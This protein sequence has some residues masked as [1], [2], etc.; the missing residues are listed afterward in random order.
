MK[1]KLIAVLVLA[2][3]LPVLVFASVAN[4]QTFRSGQT[5]SIASSESIDGAAFITGSAVDVAGTING[6]L[7]CAGQNVT[8]SGNVDGDVLC[9]AQTITISGSVTGDVRLAAQTIAISGDVKGSASIAAQ[10]ITIEGQGKI[11]RDAVI[12]GQSTTINGSIARDVTLS[13]GSAVINTAIGRNISAQIE[14]LTLGK[15]AVIGGTIDYTS[16]EMLTKDSNAQVAGKVTY[17]KQE[18]TQ[19]DTSNAYDVSGAIFSTLMLIVSALLLVLIFPRQFQ[20]TT[21]ASAVSVKH[22]MFALLTGFVAS[23]V[24]PVAIVILLITVVGIPLGILMLLAW[25]I[26]LILSISFASYYIGR[27]VWRSQTNAIIIML[28][29]ALI[30]A[31]ALLIPVLDFFV[32]ILAFWYGSG[33]ILLQLRAHMVAPRYDMTIVPSKKK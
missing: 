31:V 33:A 2:L 23:I 12:A 13:S 3:V 28:I 9:A 6:D 10:T 26:V 29:G 21:N 7:Y 5:P 27:I 22:T 18:T 8:I 4:A 25:I 24:V 11:G 1:I 16:P 15:S 32:L 19:Q 14:S 20:R 30:L 17:T